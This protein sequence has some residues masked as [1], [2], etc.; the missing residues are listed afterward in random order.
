MLVL[1]R[2][3]GQSIILSTSDGRVKIMFEKVSRG[4]VRVGIEAPSAIVIHRN[5][6]QE[7]IDKDKEKE[8]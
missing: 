1:T 6:V 2:Y 8:V 7:C 4:K 5:E 3:S